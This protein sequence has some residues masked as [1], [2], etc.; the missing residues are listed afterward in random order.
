MAGLL[1]RSVHTGWILFDKYLG[2][3]LY[4]VMVYLVLGLTRRMP[5]GRTA[6]FAMGVMTAIEVFQLTLI[7]ARLLRIEYLLVRMA[8][9]NASEYDTP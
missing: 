7:P 1:S 5:A 4:A 3:A 9:R 8:E 2:D 6:L